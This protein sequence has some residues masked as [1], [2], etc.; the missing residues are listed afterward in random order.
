MEPLTCSFTGAQWYHALCRCLQNCMLH[1][2]CSDLLC[3]FIYDQFIISLIIVQNIPFEFC[4]SQGHPPVLCLITVI[5]LDEAPGP[6][7][8]K[9][10]VAA[11][12]CPDAPGTLTSML[13]GYEAQYQRV[14][15]SFN[16]K[17]NFF[18]GL[19]KLS[20][21]RIK[22]YSSRGHNYRPFRVI[23]RYCRIIGL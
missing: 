21:W 9:Q 7:G 15:L 20:Y 22:L 1:W 5:T 6:T 4:F 2:T 16:S 23:I 11:I 14:S 12:C 17:Q 13:A 3:P 18:S 19:V 8:H 10:E